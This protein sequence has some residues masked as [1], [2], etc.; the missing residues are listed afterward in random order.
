MPHTRTPLRPSAQIFAVA[1]ASVLACGTTA[2]ADFSVTPTRVELKAS[3]LS[4]AVSVINHAAEPLRVGVR[5]V[6]WSQ[7]E[8]GNDVYK[9]SSDLVYFPR[10]ME[11]DPDS[12]RIVRLGTKTPAA[13]MERSYRLFIEEQPAPTPPGARAQISVAFR[14]GLPVFLPPAVPRVQ[15]EVGEPVLQQG[16]LSIALKNAGNEHV[17]VNT[18][19]V[20]GEGGFT[21]DVQGWYALPGAQRT[22]SMDLPRDACRATKVLAVSLE[23]EG[24]ATP[25]DRKLPVDRASCG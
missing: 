3:A 17:R 11:V 5:L 23:L 4:E 1:A 22:F 19:R 10:Q 8:K 21:K 7:D 20:T 2:A 9:D 14:F 15:V 25:I 24:G 18:M 6:E 16:K 13:T 12:R